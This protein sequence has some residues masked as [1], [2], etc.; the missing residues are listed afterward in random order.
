MIVKFIR[1]LFASAT[2][3]KPVKTYKY[4]FTFPDEPDAPVVIRERNQREARAFVRSA[5]DLTRLPVGT[6]VTRLD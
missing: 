6:D 5:F 4:R 3:Q 1:S 2:A